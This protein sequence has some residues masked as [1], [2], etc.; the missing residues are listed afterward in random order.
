[1]EGYLLKWINYVYGW[2]RKYFV[3]SSGILYFSNDKGKPYKGAIHLDISDVI[4]HRNPKRIIINTGS[5]IIHLKA[6]TTHDAKL[7]TDA[8][9]DN[10]NSL[11]ED[12]LV[13]R[14]RLRSLQ[15][16]VDQQK[17]QGLLNLI[18]RLWILE[19]TLQE[20]L[21]LLQ[22][23]ASDLP[24]AFQEFTIAAKEFK[25]LSLDTLNTLEDETNECSKQMEMIEEKL[26]EVHTERYT[27]FERRMTMPEF[28]AN[29]TMNSVL[30]QSIITDEYVDARSQYDP[31]VLAPGDVNTVDYQF[32]SFYRTS[33]PVKKD[34]NTKYNIWKIIKDSIG[35]DL[36]K[37]AV[38]VY[39][40]EPLSFLQRF[41]EDLTYN[42]IILRASECD[43]PGLRMAYIACFA[44]SCYVSTRNRTMKP[45]NPLLGETFEYQQDGYSLIAE[46]V[47]HHPPI[48]ALHC[49]HPCY[50]YYG[51][52]QVKSNFKG[53]FL[54]IKPIGS[55]N[56]FIH[57]YND[58]YN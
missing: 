19:S 11:H 39:F 2:S 30:N 40:N 50:T 5:S 41:S 26:R 45:F 32:G 14:E 33:L 3:L 25:T 55:M 4:T 37:M 17:F 31:S 43:D 51:D 54:R 49:E 20:K 23:E 42:E 36:S 48:T 53:T 38:P 10:K 56:L 6:F 9:R 16:V 44:V 1:M 21:S 8:L 28:S 12:E 29:F 57:K 15:P 35:S 24:Y 13:S 34:P 47:S 22:D 18:S 52:S 7:W 27:T 58:H 46:Q